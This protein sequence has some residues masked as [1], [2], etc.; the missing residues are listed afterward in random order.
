[1]KKRIILNH[2]IRRLFRPIVVEIVEK[3]EQCCTRLLSGRDT[4]QLYVRQ[5]C[6]I[7]TVPVAGAVSSLAPA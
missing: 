1:M 6:M 7:I 5:Q 4:R 3:R 2:R